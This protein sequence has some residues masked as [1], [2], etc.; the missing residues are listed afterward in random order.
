MHRACNLRPGSLVN[1]SML[2]PIGYNPFNSG[3]HAT[4]Q[5]NDIQAQNWCTFHSVHTN[6]TAWTN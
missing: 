1:H 4:D 5:A 2:E 6:T 3:K